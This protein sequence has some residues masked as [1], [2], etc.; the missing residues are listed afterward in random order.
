MP[1]HEREETD[2]VTGD[3]IK[4]SLR[5]CL[6]EYNSPGKVTWMDFMKVSAIYIIH[7]FGNELLT[8]YVCVCVKNA[9][10]PYS[11]ENQ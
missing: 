10:R 9:G 4:H 7:Y 11:R 1:L 5:A 6:D 8:T 2:P 3:V